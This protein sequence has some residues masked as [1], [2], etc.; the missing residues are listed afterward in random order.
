[1][2][3]GKEEHQQVTAVF[4]S[5]AAASHSSECFYIGSSDWTSSDIFIRSREAGEAYVERLESHGSNRITGAVV[6]YIHTDR[7]RHRVVTIA[8]GVDMSLIVAICVAFDIKFKKDK[9]NE[10]AVDVISQ[11]VGI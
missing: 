11:L 2:D 10:V 7:L 4:T 3:A 5:V 9:E 8:P 6:A 1:M